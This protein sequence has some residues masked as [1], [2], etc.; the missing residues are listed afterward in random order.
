MS[1]DVLDSKGEPVAEFSD[2][3]DALIFQ[4]NDEEAEDVVDHVTHVVLS[5]RK[6]LKPGAHFY[7]QLW[8]LD[9]DPWG[10]T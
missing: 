4:R 1:F 10:S 3:L 5:R 9:D 6:R 2:I 8:N 7:T